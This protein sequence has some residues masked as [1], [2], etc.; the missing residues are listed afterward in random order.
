MSTETKQNLRSQELSM[1]KTVISACIDQT[2]KLEMQTD[3]LA[4][5]LKAEQAAMFRLIH[6]ASRF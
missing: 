4:E 3:R 6:S 5:W 1:F 2:H